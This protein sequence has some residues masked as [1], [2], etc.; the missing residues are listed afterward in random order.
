MLLICCTKYCTQH[1]VV[2]GFTALYLVS[3]NSSFVQ[4]LCENKTCQKILHADHN[5]FCIYSLQRVFAFFFSLC[6]AAR[7][8]LSFPSNTALSDYFP[9][10]L[11]PS[12]SRFDIPSPGGWRTVGG[13]WRNYSAAAAAARTVMEPCPVCLMWRATP[14]LYAAICSVHVPLSLFMPC[15]INTLL[16]ILLPCRTHLLDLTPSCGLLLSPSHL[17]FSFL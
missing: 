12:T 9:M 3:F 10:I 11:N 4:G 13:M 16:R 8:G 5:R 15:W 6:K 1:I 14:S 7:H 2:F 17:H